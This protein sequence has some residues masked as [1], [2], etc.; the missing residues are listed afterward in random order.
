MKIYV[1]QQHIN[2]GVRGSC[3]QDPISL[4][5]ADAGFSRPW[6][7]PVCLRAGGR[8]FATPP[9]VLEFMKTF[10]NNYGPVYPFEF[11]V[12]VSG[13]FDGDAR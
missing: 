5:L 10:D 4:A 13:G 7:G 11:E 8:E 9:E 2:S 1:S 12:G 3:T 6:S